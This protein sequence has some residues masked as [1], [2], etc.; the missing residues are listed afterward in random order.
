MPVILPTKK[1]PQPIIGE[2][3][4]FIKNL[5]DE[6]QYRALLSRIKGKK[7]GVITTPAFRNAETITNLLITLY[8]SS[9]YM[10]CNGRK[11]VQNTGCFGIYPRINNGIT[12][13][14]L[15]GIPISFFKTAIS[16]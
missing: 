16:K 3:A 8:G 2:G 15:Q 9:M 4:G 6:K 11:K 7:A 14:F 13:R 10:R 1:A 12:T 5:Q